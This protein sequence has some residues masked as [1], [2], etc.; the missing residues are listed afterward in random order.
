MSK[1][2]T[3]VPVRILEEIQEEIIKI[4]IHR[5]GKFEFTLLDGETYITDTTF[6]KKSKID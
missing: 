6:R 4:F 5:H 2:E 3:I 1:E